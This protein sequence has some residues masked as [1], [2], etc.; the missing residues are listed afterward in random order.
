MAP[1]QCAAASLRLLQA[2]KPN[3]KRLNDRIE[4]RWPKPKNELPENYHDLIETLDKM[5][6]IPQNYSDASKDN[7]RGLRGRF[8]ES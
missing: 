7:I 5:T 8:Y 2:S 1:R 3:L 6:A 4:R